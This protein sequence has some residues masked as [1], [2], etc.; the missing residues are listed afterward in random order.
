MKYLI[1]NMK[2]KNEIIGIKV[3]GLLNYESILEEALAKREQLLEVKTKLETE[4][5][6]LPND[7]KSMSN[8]RRRLALEFELS[9][10]YSQ[11]ISI[12]NKIKRYSS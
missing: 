10:N 3:S 6:S 2:I 11:L 7:S 4:F 9:M 12:N 8:K 5:K 1:I